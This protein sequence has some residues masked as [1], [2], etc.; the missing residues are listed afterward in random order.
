MHLSNNPASAVKNYWCNRIVT[1][2]FLKALTHSEISSIISRLNVNKAGSFDEISTYFS[3]QS[4]PFVFSPYP[5]SYRL[6]NS[7]L[8]QR[9]FPDKLKI[10]KVIPLFKSGIK[11][12][13]NNYRPISLLSCFS[14]IFEKLSFIV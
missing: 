2:V 1:S 12:D 9:I 7:S 11:S 14:K 8:S 5:N 4:L 10:A 3:L 6:I 13:V